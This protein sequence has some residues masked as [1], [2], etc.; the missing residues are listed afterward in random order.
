MCFQ[1]CR[2]E[3]FAGV[4]NMKSS[5]LVE[6]KLASIAMWAGARRPERSA[7]SV[8]RGRRRAVRRRINP[9]EPS[10]AYAR[11]PGS[12]RPPSAARGFAANFGGDLALTNIPP[13][14][15]GPLSAQEG[16]VATPL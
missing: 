3:P 12:P 4:A 15:S 2:S 14:P 8:S 13:Q 7:V 16:G 11:H 6:A 5:Q 9:S 1:G 10:R